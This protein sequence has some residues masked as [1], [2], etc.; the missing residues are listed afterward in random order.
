[1]EYLIY[2]VEDDKDISKI[3]NRT[4]T[5]QGYNVESFYD[6]KSFLEELKN[7]KPDMILLD[8]MLPDLSGSELLKI[9]RSNSAYDNIQIIIISANSLVTDKIDGLDMG[10]DDYLAKPFDLLEL[11]A[12]VNARF[13]QYKKNNIYTVKE[14]TLDTDSFECRKGNEVINLTVKEFQ[15]LELLLK[16][17]GKTVTRDEILNVIW[18]E[19]DIET[20]AIDMHIKAIRK[21]LDD[22]SLIETVYGRGYK[23]A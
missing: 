5:K 20:R 17:R 8:M 12:R 19:S 14:Y 22:D 23:I 1:M 13:R 16:E 21:K 3:I 6:G 18:G 4:L 7:K 9:I 15:I 10:A 2:S 11:V